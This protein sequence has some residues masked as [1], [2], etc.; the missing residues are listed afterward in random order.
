[1][2]GSGDLIYKKIYAEYEADRLR[3]SKEY[4]K[5]LKS[6]YESYPSI[7]KI[8][9]SL[10]HNAIKLSKAMIYSDKSDYETK[11]I[12]LQ[13]LNKKLISE[14]SELIRSFNIVDNF[15]TDIYKCSLC[16]D[17]G[18]IG[19]D[20][21]RE[22]KCFKQK[23]MS[24]YYKLLGLG[25]I[26]DDEIFNRFDFEYYSQNI[27]DA[28]GKTPRD[29]IEL[30]YY[31]CLNFV[32]NFDRHFINLIFYG[33]PGLGKTFL[34]NC[35]A[36][37]IEAK[38][39]SV[40]YITAPKLFKIVDYYRFNKSNFYDNFDPLRIVYDV[41]LLIVD[42]LGAEVPGLI[43]STELFNII[44]NRLTSRRPTIFSSNLDPSQY[45]KLYSERVTSRFVGSY[46][47]IKFIGEDIRKKKKHGTKVKES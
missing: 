41:E 27:R 35:I 3:S 39:S 36:K 44:D 4:K 21:I 33:H 28:Y 46:K 45:E 9:E 43:G 40:I 30:I 38:G 5:R 7:K 18:Y 16:S 6:L 37:E 47:I 12:H 26:N 32:E 14:K 19:T 24:T 11:L 23:K 31:T 1:M 15:L 13:S 8:D 42:D 20:S 2:N 17:T 10:A 25:E 29:R 34:C 22:C